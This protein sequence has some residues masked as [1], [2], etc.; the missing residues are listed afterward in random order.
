V[1]TGKEATRVELIRPTEQYL[2]SYREAVAE[3]A[4]HRPHAERIFR[5]PE[6]VVARS[7]AAE[8][9]L[10]LR[11]GYVPVTV[12]WLVDGGR[13]LGQI[14]IRHALTPALLRYGGHIGYE[15][16]WSACGQGCGT[17]MPA[18][19]LP[20]CREELELTRVLI[21][22]DDDNYASARVIEKNG[23]VL[24][25]KVVNHLDR[26]TVTTRRYWIAL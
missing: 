15:V 1:N 3:D 11:P 12:F 23:G 2:D 4:A 10:G 17:R 6:T 9:G 26:G 25:N 22:C 13:F 24:E 8:R 20:F 7:R 16:R 19:A 14:D 21:T 18:L 5:D